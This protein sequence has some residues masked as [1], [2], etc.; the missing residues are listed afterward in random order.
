MTDT[1]ATIEEVIEQLR[2]ATELS[3]T[4]P[5][6]YRSIHRELND[7]FDKFRRAA[8]RRLGSSNKIDPK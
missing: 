3:K 7:L 4:L 2:N 8:R 1:E 5:Q 6:P